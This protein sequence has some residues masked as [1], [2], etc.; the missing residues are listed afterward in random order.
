MNAV[1]CYK[2]SFKTGHFH[3]EEVKV[4]NGDITQFP[5][6]APNIIFSHQIKQSKSFKPRTLKKE[7]LS[8]SSD[9]IYGQMQ[10]QSL[11]TA[12]GEGK[13]MNYLYILKRCTKLNRFVYYSLYAI[14]KKNIKTPRPQVLL[15]PLLLE[16][17][18]L[19]KHVPK[20]CQNAAGCC[21]LLTSCCVCFTLLVIS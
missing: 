14:D 6:T 7:S 12:Q 17:A 10:A 1:S 20:A 13:I 11:K 8:H 5:D 15:P 21:C 19:L 16:S 3:G 18:D 4:K 2:L 9:D